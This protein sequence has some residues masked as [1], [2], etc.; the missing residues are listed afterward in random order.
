M[1][2]TCPVVNSYCNTKYM[3]VIIC[4]YKVKVKSEEEFDF[5]HVRTCMYID[6]REKECNDSTRT[7]KTKS[8]HL[9]NT[10]HAS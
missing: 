7:L 1:A 10:D 5:I 9:C 3:E 4:K 6:S 2:N 8:L